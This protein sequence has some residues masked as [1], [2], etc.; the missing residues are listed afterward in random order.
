MLFDYSL[1][2][3]SQKEFF[4]PFR[5]SVSAGIEDYRI[6]WKVLLRNS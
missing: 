6:L 3:A 4:K 5:A 2:G 1:Q